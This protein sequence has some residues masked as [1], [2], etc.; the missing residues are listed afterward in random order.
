MDKSVFE[1]PLSEAVYS[2]R[3]SSRTEDLRGPYFRDQTAII[4]SLPF[5]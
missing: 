4:H 1:N 5:R 3:V 2:E